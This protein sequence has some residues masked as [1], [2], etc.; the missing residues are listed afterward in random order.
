MT[1]TQSLRLKI[2]SKNYSMSWIMKFKQSLNGLNIMKRYWIAET[3]FK[4]PFPD[5]LTKKQKTLKK[6][7]LGISLENKSAFSRKAS[8]QLKVNVIGL[9]RS[10]WDLSKKKSSYT[11]FFIPFSIIISLS[12]ISVHPN[13]GRRKN[14]A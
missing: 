13:Q 6:N 5:L 1:T 11:V 3:N 4:I 12:G 2:Q 8:N 9:Y 7:L 10:K 14:L